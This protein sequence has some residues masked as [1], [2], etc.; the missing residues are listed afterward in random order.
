MRSFGEIIRSQRQKLKLTQKKVAEEAE[1][2]DAY[3]C[4][5]E[6]DKKTPPP[7]YTVVKIANALELD[8]E[9]LWKVAVKSREK[10]AV[11]KI[12][13]KKVIPRKE[14]DQSWENIPE[15]QID[16]FF[17]IGENQ[18]TV[19][20]LLKKQPADLTMEEKR[21]VYQALNTA[22]KFVL[23]QADEPVSSS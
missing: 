3:I 5:L 15:S 2:S 12:Q 11:A 21:F 23:D 17:K 22:Q 19:F 10:L 4:S 13:R 9:K 1:V 16:A 20:S 18:V 7:Y 6:S 14:G 8:A